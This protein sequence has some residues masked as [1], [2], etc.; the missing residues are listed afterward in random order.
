MFNSASVF[1]FNCFT[2]K[3]RQ[4]LLFTGDL[5]HANVILVTFILLLLDDYSDGIS[6]AP[7]CGNEL[8]FE[9]TNRPSGRM[10]QAACIITSCTS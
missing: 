6:L 1:I 4:F 7:F 10:S 3:K 5:N 9:I 2:K 8:D